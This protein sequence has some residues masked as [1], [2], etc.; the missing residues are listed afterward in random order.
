MQRLNLFA[1]AAVCWLTITAP[2]MA[3]E[4]PVIEKNKSF[5]K[6]NL[7]IKVGDSVRFINKDPY[8]HNVYSRTKGHKFDVGPQP[9]GASNSISFSKPG[10]IQVRCAIH[11][12]MKLTLMVDR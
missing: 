12:K 7:T 8:V 2:A 10:K 6:R 9:S 3:A 1:V 5:D 4:Y 11:P